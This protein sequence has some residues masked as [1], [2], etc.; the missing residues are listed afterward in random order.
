MRTNIDIDDDLLDRARVISKS[1]TKREL[2][3]TALQFY[4][5]HQGRPPP[6][7]TRMTDSEWRQVWKAVQTLTA[8][9]PEG[10]IV[11]GGVAVYLHSLQEKSLA[12]E[13]THDA[14]VYVSLSIWAD[15]RDMYDVT[16]NKRL[17]KHQIILNDVDVDVYQER[18]NSLR[19]PYAALAMAAEVTQG[20]RVAGLEH[21]LLLKLDAYK[22]RGRSAHGLKDARDVAKILI[23]LRKTTPYYVL[24]QGT[25][26]DVELIDRVLRSDVFLI[27]AENNAH[28]ASKLRKMASIYA[29]ALR[30]ALE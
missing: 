22:D 27:L 6:S 9:F 12:V 18:N 7:E 13:F 4:L 10:V 17:S 30:K 3:E 15:F 8:E 19:V 24:A 11:I 29:E 20:V 21:L 26:E 28:E 2:I 14:D 23:L 1:R 25:P 16:S 5:L